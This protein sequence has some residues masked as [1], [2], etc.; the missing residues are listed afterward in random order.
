MKAKRMPV[1]AD[2]KKFRSNFNRTKKVN[3]SSAFQQGGL[4]F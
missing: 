1:K 2:R 4:R 3:K